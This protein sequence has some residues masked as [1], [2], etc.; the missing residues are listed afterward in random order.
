MSTSLT[1][2]ASY[3]N[4]PPRSPICVEPYGSIP[5]APE[6]LIAEIEMLRE[7]YES[8]VGPVDG[9]NVVAVMTPHMDW[10]RGAPVYAQFSHLLHQL[11]RPDVIV[12]LG[13]A[14]RSARSGFVYAADRR[15]AT[16]LG[17][18]ELE[19]VIYHSLSTCPV[20]LWSNADLHN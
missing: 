12:M 5:R 17:V 14:H 8:T 7:A 15:Y 3:T 11:P 18:V 10:H 2:A 19:Q 20:P 16:P 13:V 6:P 1:A 9:E 4:L